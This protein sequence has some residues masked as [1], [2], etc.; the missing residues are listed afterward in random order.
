MLLNNNDRLFN[1]KYADEKT[2]EKLFYLFKKQKQSISI[3]PITTGAST[4]NYKITTHEDK[5]Y[6]LRIYPTE[7]DHSSL[8][9][10]TYSFVKDFLNVP[11]VLFYD[12][13]K[14]NFPLA[15]TFL[16]YIEGCTLKEYLLK[17]KKID[18]NIPFSIGAALGL[19]HEHK[20]NEMGILDNNFSIIKP[21]GTFEELINKYLNEVAGT[22]LSLETKE[23][24]ASLLLNKSH[25]ISQIEEE[26]VLSHGD[27]NFS[28]II[29]DKDN[30]PWFIDFEYCFSAPKYY[31]IGKFFRSNIGIDKNSLS[32]K[33][34]SGYNSVSSK[35]LPSNW[36]LL[37]KFMEIQTLLALINRKNLP[38]GWIE[39]VE[40]EILLNI[41]ILISN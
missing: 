14:F 11:E 27:F 25:L 29:I 18:E 37:S 19:L 35:F 9:L 10:S 32:E 8:E 22:H 20:F 30:E 1:F 5:N 15:Y 38:T 7:N 31:D 26:Y 21:L 17:T 13:S 4:S 41:Y 24:I 33:F 23:K 36:F 28:N 34:F 12:N 39:E 6:L 3:E 2:I 40:K 16:E